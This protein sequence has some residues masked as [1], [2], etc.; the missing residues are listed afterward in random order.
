EAAR[1]E[2]ARPQLQYNAVDPDNRLV[3]GELE[4]R[5]NRALEKF[6][7]LQKRL[8]EEMGRMAACEPISSALLQTLAEDFDRVW[9]SEATDIRLKK[10]IARTLIEEIIAD[11]SPEGSMIELVIHWKGGVHTPL[12]VARRRRGQSM[13]ATSADTLDAIRVLAH[14]C[15]DDG[16]AKALNRS[17]AKTATELVWTRSR[18]KDVRRHHE[19]LVFDPERQ[20]VEGWFKLG[21]AAMYLGVTS[22]TVRKQVELGRVVALHPVSRGP[23]VLRRAELGRPDWFLSAHAPAPRVVTDGRVNKGFACGSCHL[24]NGLGHPESGDIHGLTPEYFIQTMKDFKSGKRKDPIR[25]TAIAQATPEEDI[26]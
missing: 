15:T 14:V 19:I 6:N 25:M 11:I 9:N 12:H 21:E 4:A 1:V 10:R 26:A 17:G 2:A 24:M 8:E 5:W 20:R 3:A 23:W 16:I 7:G 18:V 13:V 22:A